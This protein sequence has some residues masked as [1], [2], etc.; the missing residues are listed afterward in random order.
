MDDR[1]D[2]L[3]VS[4]SILTETSQMYYIE[5]SYTAF[6]NDGNHFN[7]A[8]NSGNN[9]AVSNEMADALHDASDHLPVYMDIWYDDLVYS[10]EIITITEVMPNPSS[11]QSCRF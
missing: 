4:E 8:I 1:F 10:D 2:W 5:D 7:D 9:G 6:G 11:T 3:L